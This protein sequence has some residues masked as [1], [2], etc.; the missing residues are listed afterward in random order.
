MEEQQ[1][2]ADHLDELRAE[3]LAKLERLRAAGV[4]PYPV[5]V[6]VDDRLS[7]VVQRF[8]GRLE[9]GEG[10]GEH[11]RVAGRIVARRQF[12]KLVFLVLREGDAD[13]QLLCT[14]SVLGD[15]GMTLVADLDLGDW[16]A[17]A[18]EVVRSKKGELSVQ[19]AEVTLIGKSLRPL[20]DK[21][22]GLRDTETR[23]RQREVD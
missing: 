1:Q 6:R 13:L 18:G 12:G 14:K 4:D 22:H 19:A 7:D 17:A 8:D 23:F 15:A 16:L 2:P 3:R 11:V 20:P 5:G 21:W 10:S 9:P